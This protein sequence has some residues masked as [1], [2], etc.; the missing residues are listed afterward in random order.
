IIQMDVEAAFDAVLG[1]PTAF[2]FTNVTDACIATPACLAAPVDEQNNFLFFDGVHPTE[3]GHALIAQYAA[4]LFATDVAAADQ[5]GLGQAATDAQLAV[6][7]QIFDRTL[8]WID[9]SY[10]RENGIHAEVIG[11]F[12]DLGARG[13][14]AASHTNIYGVRAGFDQ[15]MG[16]TL[17]GVSGAILAGDTRTGAV[18][19]DVLS[20]NLSAYGAAVAGPLYVSGTAGVGV[21]AFNDVERLTGFGNT[22]TEGATEAFNLGVA[23]EV[24]AILKAGRGFALIPSVRLGHVFGS[25]SGYEESGQVLALSYADRDTNV[26]YWSGQLRATSTTSFGSIYGEVGYEDFIS[27]DDDAVTAQLVD[28]TALPVTALVDDPAGRGFFINIGANSRIN[29]T[30]S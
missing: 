15:Q 26:T 2:G 25:V 3:A 23:G 19:A 14:R 1:D 13:N 22:K 29:E 5:V 9:G 21:T 24:G 7:N 11:A 28:N 4:L 17:L 16:D 8:D 10:A 27:N 20:F 30:I 18:S 6:T 12:S